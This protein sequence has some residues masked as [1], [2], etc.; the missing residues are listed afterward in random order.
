MST[1]VSDVPTDSPSVEWLG[2]LGYGAKGIVYTMVGVL[3]A[4][5]VAGSG[6]ELTG[7]TGALTQL[8]QEPYGAAMLVVIALGLVAYTAWRWA[9]AIIDVENKGSDWKGLV[10]RAGL[11]I[12][13]TLYAALAWSA[14]MLSR[15]NAQSS[16]PDA[17]AAEAMSIPGGQWLVMAV[18][19]GFILT[20]LYQFYRVWHDS[21]KKHWKYTL[22]GTTREWATRFSR[23]G[24]AA[25]AAVFVIMG[26][27]MLMA[28]LERNPEQTRGMGAVLAE[29]SSVPWLLAVIAAGLICYGA[30]SLINAAFRE[31]PAP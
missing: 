1:A 15:G 14:L 13:G 19:A 7:T 4:M 23:F 30:Y 25:R 20:A 28:G 17:K 29:L 9:Q 18:G 21:F 22:S 24:I 8:R 26:A 10:R 11:F 6:G 27:Y 12:S 3:A 31:I 2:R 5:R 16:D